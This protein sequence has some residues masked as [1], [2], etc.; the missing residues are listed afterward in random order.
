MIRIYGNPLSPPANKVRYVANQ[1]NIPHEFHNVNLREG[2]QRQPEFLKINPL[3]KIPALR[4]GGYS[5]GESNAIIRYLADKAG[6]PIYP[7]D[8]QQRG[9]V[10]QWIDF[11]T[12]HI[13]TATSKVM[14]NTHFYKFSDATIDER[15]LKDGR[16]WLAKYLPMVEQQ[17]STHAYLTGD[18]LTLADIV[19][20]SALDVCEVTNIDLTPYT[21]LTKWR[22]N[23]MQQKWYRT[24]HTDYAS[25]FN[26]IMTARA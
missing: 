2:E 15:S 21:A 16:D 7:R 1:L 18:T 11:A 8:L 13:A 12:Q 3:G 19:M 5:L 25:T 14:F 24:C 26:T 17:L 23:L 20:L 9:Q 22:K 4:D 10:D 6:S